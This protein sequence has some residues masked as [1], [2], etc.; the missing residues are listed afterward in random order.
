M[1][2]IH[3]VARPR[4]GIAGALLSAVAAALASARLS[5][6]S[7]GSPSRGSP[8]EAARLR[9][10]IGLPPIDDSHWRPYDRW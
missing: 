10:D 7:L 2:D 4:P 6:I 1:N 3:S 5:R 8:P 9:A